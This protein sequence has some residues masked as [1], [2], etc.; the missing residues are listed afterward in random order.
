MSPATPEPTDIRSI[1]VTAEDVVAAVETSRTTDRP[2]VLRITPPFSGR[3]RARLH[4]PQ[5]DGQ[6][7]TEAIHIDPETLL[8]PD[9]PQYPRPAETED[10]M[11][12]DPEVEYSVEKHRTRHE[13]TVKKWRTDLPEYIRE[14]ATLETAA[15]DHNVTV[16]V[17]G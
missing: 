12:A 2:A 17:L 4:V 16:Y 8:A 13:R 9:A 11:R 7:D 5:V 1:A 10:A 14:Q 3:M 6:A 15:G